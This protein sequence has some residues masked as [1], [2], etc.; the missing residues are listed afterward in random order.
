M[1][2]MRHSAGGVDSS[3]MA[4]PI[5]SKPNAQTPEP[6]S[7][8]ASWTGMPLAD[9]GD[10]LIGTTLNGTYVVLRLL[11]K[12]GMGCIY[13]ARHTRIERRRVAIKVLRPELAQVP[14]VHGRFR[15]EAEAAATISHPNVLT[16]F[17]VDRT[18]QGWPYLVSELLV[19]V[20]LSVYLERFGRL[21]PLT[22]IHVATQVCDALQAAHQLG[23]VH[24]DVK[25]QNVFLVG[26]FSAGP[27]LSPMVKV[28]DFGLSRF[29]D[30]SNDSS[31]TKVGVVMGTPSYMAPEQARGLRADHCADIYGM[32]RRVRDASAATVQRAD[33]ASHDCGR[34]AR[35]G[36]RALEPFISD[37]LSCDPAG[38]GE[39][40]SRS[41]SGHGVARPRSNCRGWRW[42]PA[43]A[44]TGGAQSIWI[45]QAGGGSGHRAPRAPAARL[46]LV[47]R[48]G[49]RGRV[50]RDDAGGHRRVHQLAELLDDAA[51]RRGHVAHAGCAARPARAPRRLG[52]QREGPRAARAGA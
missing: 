27:S 11:S 5:A 24:R 10:P 45:A 20:D 37:S 41:L 35:P 21:G 40:A 1:L 39:R 8:N 42:R 17:D 12:G 26:D 28:L 2:A 23:V 30:A 22:A 9:G 31:L 49:R 46:L 50:A 51:G 44:R 13:E 3:Y 25:P 32:A 36:R 16:L 52:K 29:L 43:A 14:E 38:H 18:P 34:G 33:A 47:A 19:G 48:R 15:R 6:E 7:P 4:T